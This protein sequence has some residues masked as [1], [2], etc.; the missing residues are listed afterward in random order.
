MTQANTLPPCEAAVFEVEEHTA[1]CLALGGSASAKPPGVFLQRAWF[2]PDGNEVALRYG[3][4]GQEAR[5]TAIYRYSNHEWTSSK[6]RSVAFD[7]LE[8]QQEPS[9]MLTVKE[10]LNERPTSGRKTQATG[11]EMKVWDPNPYFEQLE[12][13]QACVYHWTDRHGR[14][15]TGGLSSRWDMSL[16]IGIPW[17]YRHMDSRQTNLCWM[18]PT[19]PQRS[20]RTGQFRGD[21]AP[22]WT[23]RRSRSQRY[24]G[25][26]QRQ[27]RSLRDSDR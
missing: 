27:C 8:K 18:A 5:D 9:I 14:S 4:Y 6:A 26:G 12:I 23:R 10:E 19:Q 17:S 21:R 24:R 1:H 22:G 2:G 15:W 20:T 11:K 16:I 7:G 13:P 25:G 3:L